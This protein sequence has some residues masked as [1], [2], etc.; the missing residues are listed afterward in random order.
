MGDE[1]KFSLLRKILGALGLSSEDVDDLIRWVSDL[2]SDRKGKP[3]D[4]FPYHLRDDFL[5]AAEHNFYLVLNKAVSDWAVVCPKVSLRDLFFATA[6]EGGLRL[7]YTN[8]ID[9]KHIDFLLCDPQTVRPL[10]G[11][12]LDDK[13][14]RRKERQEKDRFVEEVFR[15][16]K[17]PLVRISVQ[18]TYNVGELSGLLRQH[19]GLG[20]AQAS[21]RQDPVEPVVAETGTPTCPKCGSPMV[22]RTAK[23]GSSPG[24]Q[25]WGCPNYPRCRGIRQYESVSQS[26]E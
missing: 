21:V 11:I 16:A 4:E 10:V 18:R 25:F 22:L 12:E 3:A 26:A 8:K 19:A 24:S 6:D 1:G 17:L 5:S 7:A 15:A 9:R 23:R 2:L 13:S 20:D 14:H